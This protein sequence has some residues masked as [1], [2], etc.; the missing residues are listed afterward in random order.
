MIAVTLLAGAAWLLIG[1]GLDQLLRASGVAPTDQ[2]A[3]SADIGH[4]A[5]DFTV[6]GEDGREH[7][8]SELRGQVV[9][10]NFWATWCGPCRSEMPELER[11]YQTN[12]GKGLNVIAMNFRETVPEAQAFFKELR[13]SFPIWLDRTGSVAELYRA[14]G[15]PSTFLVDRAGII[16]FVRVG[17]VDQTMLENQLGTVL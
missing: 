1:N 10:L 15:L 12:R 2:Q 8:L 3:A 7:R 13:L 6:L 9:L 14:R 4:P 5:P 17:P 11:T 16:R